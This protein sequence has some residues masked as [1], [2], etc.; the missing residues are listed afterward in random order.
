MINNKLIKILKLTGY[1]LLFALIFILGVGIFTA[2]IPNSYFTR[3]TP[4]FWFDYV[5]LIVDGLLLGFYL[6]SLIIRA[7]AKNQDEKALTG[8]FLGFL[9][10]ACPICN[11]VLLWAFGA[12]LLLQYLEPIRPF[13]GLL[14]VI[15]LMWAIRNL[16]YP[17]NCK[18]KSS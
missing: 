2:V 6:S 9:A 1:T 14:S 12:T 11:K 7:S 18:I 15:I 17:K 5:Y 13:I 16:Y 3:M 8:G 4:V 10:V